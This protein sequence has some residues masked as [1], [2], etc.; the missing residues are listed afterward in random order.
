MVKNI[1]VTKLIMMF[2]NENI[3]NFGNFRKFRIKIKR[4]LIK[5]LK[6]LCFSME[7]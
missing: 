2:W 1:I 4:K 5:Y 3:T 6:K 7:Y